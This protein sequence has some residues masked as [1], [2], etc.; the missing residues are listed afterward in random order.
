VLFIHGSGGG[1]HS[2]RPVVESLGRNGIDAWLLARRAHPSSTPIDAENSFEQEADDAGR[3]LDLMPSAHVVGASYG[4]LV[5]LQVARRQPERI[6]SVAAWEPLLFAV[7]PHIIPIRERYRSLVEAQDHAAAE[8]LLLEQVARVP[9]ELLRAFPPAT[10]GSA[11][12]G[13]LNDLSAL[14]GSS[15]DPA[16]WAVTDVPTLLLQGSDTWAPMPERLDDLAPHITALSRVSIEGQ[17]HFAPST[18]PERV[19]AELR[20][21]WRSLP[22]SRAVDDGPPQTPSGAQT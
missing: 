9:T 3:I 20:A 14:A 1:L 10:D 8:H 11:S 13:W 21:F 19:A 5:A 18:A 12:A 7:G 2:W 22:L 4:A 17:S 16:D 6:R 15:G